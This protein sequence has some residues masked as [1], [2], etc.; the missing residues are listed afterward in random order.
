MNISDVVV[1]DDRHSYIYFKS[2]Y[3]KPIPYR[4]TINIDETHKVSTV[5]FFSHMEF[6]CRRVEFLGSPINI[7]K[8]FYA[9]GKEGHVM[10]PGKRDCYDRDFEAPPLM[11]MDIIITACAVYFG[12]IEFEPLEGCE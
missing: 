7:P 2:E 11:A 6:G 3:F 12:V 10:L 4:I 1:V 9:I 8:E 5:A